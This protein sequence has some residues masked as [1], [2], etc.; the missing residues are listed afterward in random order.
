MSIPTTSAYPSDALPRGTRLGEY[1]IE[2]VLGHGG[3]GITYRAHDTKLNA[4]V[5]IK[6][7]FPRAYSLRA[8]DSA[9][10]PRVDATSSAALDR[11][12]WGLAAFLE[13]AQALSRF[14]HPNIVRVLRFLEENNT[15]YM[16]IDY[17][18]G[19][20]LG[21]S[22][23]RRGGFLDEHSL[24]AIFLPL[25]NGL[26]A[27]HEAG[28]L[29]LDIEPEN[30]YLRANGQPMLI[31]FGSARQIMSGS[32]SHRQVALTPGDCAPEQYPGHG[33]VGPWS[34][35]Y[36]VGATLYRC[37][38]GKTPVDAFERKQ[39]LA[40][41]RR[42]PLVPATAFERPRYAAYLRRSIECAMQLDPRQR[43][44]SAF[45]LQQGLM[46]K[47]PA[48][49]AAAA[50]AGPPQTGAYAWRQGFIGVVPSA[51]PTPGRH[52]RR[53]GTPRS[54]FEK[55]VVTLVFFA[56]L[57]VVTPKILIDLGDLTADEFYTLLD[58]GRAAVYARIE[59][60]RARLAARLSGAAADEAP[61]APPAT[62][63]APAPAYA[64]V[65]HLP[66]WKHVRPFARLGLPVEYLAFLDGARLL[67][68][69]DGA[70]QIRLWEIET[71]QVLASL[72]AEPMASG[73]AVS[74]DGRWLALP[75]R[76]NTILLWDAERRQADSQLAGHPADI[77]ALTFAPDGRRLASADIDGGIML[78]DLDARSLVLRLEDREHE[79]TALAL[80][81]NARLLA[82]GHADGGVSYWDLPSGKRLAYSPANNAP[83]LTLAFSPDGRWLAAGGDGHFLVL[84]RLRADVR[85]LALEGAP[86]TVR[87]LAFTPDGRWLVA[88]GS[89]AGIGVWDKANGRLAAL[90]PRGGDSPPLYALALSPD[91]RR[92][93]V[94]GYDRTIRLWE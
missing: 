13:E 91:G 35:V 67:A 41:K 60:W 58:T 42:D 72:R 8:G 82:A 6:E 81:A 21:A 3:F 92:L 90:F 2:D 20:S 26:Q 68:A 76:G 43:P 62:V 87:A 24:L 56:T 47:D 10:L 14:K 37:I 28:I 25:L 46:G 18:E 17:E 89:D 48:R 63:Q 30:I 70:G 12:R 9:I 66:P 59:T 44:P 50:E 86:E 51:A 65:P 45:A 32:D 78:W 39:A 85:D 94:G 84:W 55:L 49:V 4:R 93:A 61:V 15:A 57:A 53:Q 52:P 74:P 80:S 33:Q 69:A 23:R 40:Q 5:A 77:V 79:V 38:T 36:A 34:D 64:T 7:Y 27:V 31:D 75:A 54:L 16:V 29:H 73:L 88:V 83:V 22:L 1:L 71:G 19:E 11:Y